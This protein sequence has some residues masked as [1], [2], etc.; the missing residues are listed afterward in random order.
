MPGLHGAALANDA[1]LQGE[2]CQTDAAAAANKDRYRRAAP[3][4][5]A[6]SGGSPEYRGSYPDFQTQVLVLVHSPEVDVSRDPALPIRPLGS[7]Q[8][9]CEIFKKVSVYQGY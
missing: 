8:F 7:F 2:R 4:T 3:D 9:K 5:G 6:P 1:S